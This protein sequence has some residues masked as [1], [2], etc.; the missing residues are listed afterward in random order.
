MASATCRRLDIGDPILMTMSYKGS[1]TCRFGWVARGS[2]DL[3]AMASDYAQ[4]AAIPYAAAVAAWYNALRIG[5]TGDELHRAVNDRLIPLGFKIGLNA[6]HQIATDE[7]THSLSAAGSTQR[8]A[9]GMYWQAD[10]FPTLST[11]HLGAFAE[12]GIAT[13]DSALR[14]ELKERYPQMWERVEARKRF[15][16]DVLG[17]D[18]SDDLLPFSNIQAAVVPYFL[19]P[20]T[21]VVRERTK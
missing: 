8:V 20:E 2:E 10:F 14:S 1:N 17:F 18:L 11:A 9:S 6:G 16:T 12:D 13:A 5:A 4:A 21:C 19:S 15:V 3:P 7:W